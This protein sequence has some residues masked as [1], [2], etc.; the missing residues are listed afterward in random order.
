MKQIEHE[1]PQ[2]YSADCGSVNF[3]SFPDKCNVQHPNLEAHDFGVCADEA[4]VKHCNGNQPAR[5][6]LESEVGNRNE[7]K[8]RLIKIEVLGKKLE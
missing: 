3:S 1:S 4:R 7:E 5:K 6:G 8:D 2:K